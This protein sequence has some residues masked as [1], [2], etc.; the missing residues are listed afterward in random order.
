[1]GNPTDYDFSFFSP[2]KVFPHSHFHFH[3]LR[4]FSK[5]E[6]PSHQDKQ[7]NWKG[8]HFI[9]RQ[10]YYTFKPNST[11]THSNNQ[12]FWY[13]FIFYF[14]NRPTFWIQFLY[15]VVWVSSKLAEG[16]PC[17][18][19]GTGPCEK[20]Y[21]HHLFFWFFFIAFAKVSRKDVLHSLGL[22]YVC[23]WLNKAQFWVIPGKFE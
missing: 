8:F 19:K 9:L 7:R 5:T 21:N 1:M 3:I 15:F 10:R 12:S 13:I 2:W 11:T 4:R 14:I 20:F 18:C 17:P 23:K 6:T 22:D 16:M